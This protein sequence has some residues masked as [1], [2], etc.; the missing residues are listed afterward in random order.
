MPMRKIS[1][2]AT[3]FVIAGLAVAGYGIWDRC[4]E[5]VSIRT[6]I[7]AVALVVILVIPAKGEW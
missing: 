4:S 2:V 3:V 5:S 7:A 1:V 6:A